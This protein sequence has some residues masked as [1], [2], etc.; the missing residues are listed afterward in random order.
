VSLL[1]NEDLVAAWAL[2]NVVDFC[3]HLLVIDN[4]SSDRTR[5]IVDALARAHSHVEV[6]SAPDAYDT[7]RFVEPWAGRDLWVLG[8]DGDEIYDRAGL[9]RFRE[10]LLCGA[11]DDAW[12]IA[13]ATLHLAGGDIAKGAGC[14]FTTP[15]SRA[16]TKLY[17]FAAIDS[18]AQGRHQRLHGKDMAFR[19]GWSRDSLRALHSEAP[20]EESDFRC[21]HLCFLPRSA[22]ERAGGRDNPVMARSRARP[23]AGLERFARRLVGLPPNRRAAY[24]R[25]AYARGALRHGSLA[26]FG[27]PLD[28]T[29]VDPQAAS[30]L[31]ALQA[32]L[33]DG[34]AA[35]AAGLGAKGD[36]I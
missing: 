9:A 22:A 27:S 17:N 19:P 21:L 2:G 6:V 13:G 32:A 24:K 18:W 10:R 8:V 29:D 36:R 28:Y 25:D 34:R 1:R 33:D 3:D 15:D 31:A 23:L 35:A 5:A 26:G 14:G 11:F 16:V 20:W 4:N 12:A 7:H 30:A